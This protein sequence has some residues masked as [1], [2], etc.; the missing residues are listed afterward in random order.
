MQYNG[1]FIKTRCRANRPAAIS[2]MVIYL[3]LAIFLFSALS[4]IVPSGFSVGAAML[5]LGSTTLLRPRALRPT[6]NRGDIALVAAFFLYFLI[7]IINNAILHAG[8]SEYDTPLRFLLAIPAILVLL[9]YRPHP[10]T[11]WAGIAV[12][13]IGAGLLSLWLSLG[14]GVLRAS[15]STNPIQYGNIASLLAILGACGLVWASRQPKSK[16]WI[17]LLS[18]GVV[19]S[20]I[21][22]LLSESRGSWIALPLCVCIGIALLVR[23]NSIRHA[24]Y[25]LFGSIAVVGCLWFGPH[26]VLKQRTELASTEVSGY[27]KSSDAATSVGIRL[28][29]WRVGLG[30]MPGHWLAGWG[31]Q[32]MVAHKQALI[33]QGLTSPAL[34]EHTHLHNE[35]LDAMVKRGIPGLLATL[36]L[37]LV[38]LGLF[39]TLAISSR[40]KTIYA[41][42]GVMLVSS[43]MAFGLTQVFL[44]HNNGVMI[45]AFM[46]AILWSLARHTASD[47]AVAD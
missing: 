47:E 10:S 36:L 20:L 3:S 33:D 8:G 39:A 40:S 13:G 46:T 7:S 6:L 32:G 23:E 16:A 12:G 41:T 14:V 34:A 1:R 29:M 28:E 27:T 21:A 37:F 44:S 19:G 31:K 35:Y 25:L 15:G 43:Y 17:S 9:A 26:S 24:C 18:A 45:F 4:L 22:S 11:Y 38:P 30:M 42:A 2:F 5:L